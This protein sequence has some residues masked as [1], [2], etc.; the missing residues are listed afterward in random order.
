MGCETTCA[1][2]AVVTDTVCHRGNRLMIL[3]MLGT[4]VMGLQ[5]CQSGVSSTARGGYAHLP[6]TKTSSRAA[7]LPQPVAIPA[8]V[9]PAVQVQYPTDSRYQV[10]ATSHTPLLSRGQNPAGAVGLTQIYW[11]IDQI[12]QQSARRF[13]DD[14]WLMLRAD[15][16]LEGST[17]CNVL[18][19]SYLTPAVS[20]MQIKASA[21]R[22]NCGDALAQEAAL[23]DGFDQVQS[24][25]I[26]QRQLWLLDAQGRVI[27][28]AHA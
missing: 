7:S 12:Q 24:Y 10:P 22:N 27:L 16:Q 14:P 18:R 13:M 1:G 4:S 23:L 5:G 15:G 28:H 6:A 8:A 21:S 17:G 9:N 26:E 20:R 2:T 3:V 25:R 11:Q 19:G